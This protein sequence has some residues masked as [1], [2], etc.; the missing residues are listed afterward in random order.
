MK[1][2]NFIAVVAAVC[3]LAGT[4]VAFADDRAEFSPDAIPTAQTVP[5]NPGFSSALPQPERFIAIY[6]GST[7]GTYY[8]IASAICAAVDAS[9]PKHHIRCVALRSQGDLSNVSLMA[10][11]RAQF[12]IVQSNTSNDI[13]QDRLKLPT[14]R[15]VMSLHDELGVVVTAAGGKIAGIVDLRGKR[16]NLGPQGSSSRRL[17][18]QLLSAEGIQL[19]DLAAVYDAPQDLNQ[20]GLCDGQ[21]DAF[22]LWIGHPAS[23]IGTSISICGA[24]IVGMR[25]PATERLVAEHPDFFL[26]EIP[27]GTYPNQD[28]PIPSY[29][30]K[31]TLVADSRVDQDLVYWLTRSVIE[32][33]DLFRSRH[34]ALAG[35]DPHAMF[36]KGNFLP[37]H[38]GA[39]RYWREVGWLA[40]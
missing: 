21:I 28:K 9:F 35:V 25:S 1:L 30:F 8:Q 7:K 17:W 34:P 26:G 11:G 33:I 38:D 39:A 18:E 5:D 27:A 22:G 10:Q 19:S 15:S 31:A 12:I 14:G 4:A 29:G 24:R 32:N 23:A 40:K 36:E 2:R 20:R 3:V 16:V 37:F 13:A 6:S